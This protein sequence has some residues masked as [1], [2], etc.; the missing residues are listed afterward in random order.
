MEELFNYLIYL[1]IKVLF[2]V[3]FILDFILVRKRKLYVYDFSIYDYIKYGLVFEE[4][5]FGYFVYGN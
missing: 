4:V 2:L 3:V 5:C 1:Y